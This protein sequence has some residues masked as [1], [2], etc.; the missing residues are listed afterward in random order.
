MPADRGRVMYASSLLCGFRG[1]LSF[2]L[3]A[4]LHCDLRLRCG[5]PTSSNY[6]QE[7]PSLIRI[8]LVG[9]GLG[10]IISLLCSW[11]GSNCLSLRASCYLILLHLF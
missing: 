5:L 2:A 6:A 8:L 10:T 9:F 11:Y 4:M 1:A 3:V 7:T